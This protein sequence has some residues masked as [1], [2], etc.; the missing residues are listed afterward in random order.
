[1]CSCRQFY[2]ALLYSFLAA[3]IITLL[4]GSLLLHQFL[5]AVWLFLEEKATKK[6]VHHTLSA[7]L[8]LFVQFNTFG[9]LW[10]FTI[11]YLEMFLFSFWNVF[12]DFLYTGLTGFIVFLFRICLLLVQWLYTWIH[13]DF[14]FTGP[15]KTRFTSRHTHKDEHCLSS[16]SS[17]LTLFCWH[18]CPN[19]TSILFSI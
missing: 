17:R 5:V 18:T 11:H 9:C 7:L 4:I 14:I 3:Q 6:P 10:I 19:D 1:M 16:T 2:R 12:H 13:T 15:T 8:K